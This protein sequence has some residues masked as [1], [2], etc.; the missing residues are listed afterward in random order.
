MKK[1]YTGGCHCKAVRFEE[2]EVRPMGR[3]AA[4]VRGIKLGDG[5]ELV[6]L[7]VV[8]EGNILT[9]SENGYGKLTPLD[10]F[11]AHGR[12]GQGVRGIKITDY[13]D[14]NNLSTADRLELFIQV[15]H[16]VQHA[17][18]KGVIHRN[19]D[20][21][22]PRIGDAQPPSQQLYIG[23]RTEVGRRWSHGLEVSQNNRARFGEG[24]G[25][26]Y[27]LIAQGVFSRGFQS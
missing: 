16:A 10:D 2:G 17:H 14:Q 27:T 11:P 26:R 3:E 22:F 9:A 12:G 6:G 25:G 4:G 19:F 15:C 23:H 18:Q 24:S 1:T 7:I 5:H 20:R 13:C 8:G 21:F